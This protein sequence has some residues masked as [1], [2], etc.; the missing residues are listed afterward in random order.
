MDEDLYRQKL[1]WFKQNERPEVVLLIADNTERIKIVVVWGN[2]DVRRAEKLTELT[3]ESENDAWEWLW[4]NAKYSRTDL[5]EKAGIS[6]SES[7]LDRKIKP[8]IGNRVLYPDG[9]VNSFVQRYLR[10]RVVKLFEPKPK[11]STRK[12]L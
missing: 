10:D 7:A 11:R 8:L 5:M 1:A 12:S 3:G 6:L 9:N 4:Q 2:L